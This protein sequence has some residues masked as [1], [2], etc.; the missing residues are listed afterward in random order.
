M[1]Q[2]ALHL[3]TGGGAALIAS[4]AARALPEPSESGS[5]FYQWFYQ[6]FYQF[7]HLLLANFDKLRGANASQPSGN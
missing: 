5:G 1:L 7:A 6:W 4:A 2:Y 3:L